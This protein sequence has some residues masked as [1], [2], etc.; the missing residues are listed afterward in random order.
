[1]EKID[2]IFLAEDVSSVVS[3]IV[4]TVCLQEAYDEEKQTSNKNSVVLS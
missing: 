3:L 1:M 4:E 2:N